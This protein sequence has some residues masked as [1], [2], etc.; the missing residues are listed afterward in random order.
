MRVLGQKKRR[1]A[2]HPLPL[3]LFRVKIMGIKNPWNI[4]DRLMSIDVH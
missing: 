3:S 1:G 4:S 2:K